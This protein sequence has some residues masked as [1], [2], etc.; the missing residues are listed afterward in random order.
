[1]H[2]KRTPLDDVDLGSV[3]KVT[4]GFTGADLENLCREV[5]GITKYGLNSVVY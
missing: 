5:R 4:E 1:M 2:T 3:A